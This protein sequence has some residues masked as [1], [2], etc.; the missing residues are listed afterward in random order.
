MAKGAGHGHLFGVP[1]KGTESHHAVTRDE[2]GDALPEG[3]HRARHFDARHEGRSGRGLVNA[4]A[5][6]DVGE[7]D[8]RRFHGHEQFTGFGLRRR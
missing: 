2:P 5:G 7:V 1:S 4:Q 3:F 6:Q 8:S